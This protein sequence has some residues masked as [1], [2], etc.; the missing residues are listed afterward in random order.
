MTTT[1]CIISFGS[2]A[3]AIKKDGTFSTTSLNA[4]GNLDDLQDNTTVIK[5]FATYEPNFW[6]LD[7]SYKFVP[8]TNIHAGYISAAMSG[9]DTNF[10]AAP[11]IEFLFS[12][13]HSTTELKLKF[14]DSGD[15]ADSITINFFNGGSTLSSATYTPTSEEYTLSLTVTNFNK[16]ELYFNSTNKAYRYARLSNIE[17]DELTVFSGSSIK[18]AELVEQISP[19]SIELPINTI[20]FT[21]FSDT[22]DF[23][24]ANPSGMYASLQNKEAIEIRE[25]VNNSIVYIGTFYLD[26]WESK[27]INEAEFSAYD[28]IAILETF[29]FLGGYY[30][31]PVINSEDLIDEIF[32]A[33]GIDYE[34]DPT[35]S[36]IVVKGVIQYLTNCREALQQT[37][38]YLG[39]YATCAR[40]GIIRILPLPEVPGATGN[41]YELT[42]ANK[43]ISSPLTLRP[44]VTGVEIKQ[45]TYVAHDTGNL[46]YSGTL[47]VGSHF[48]SLTN[49][50]EKNIPSG[51]SQS[52]TA[53]FTITTN[54]KYYIVVNVTVAGT[55]IITEVSKNTH[56]D[57]IVGEYNPSLPAGATQNILSIDDA[58]LM[59]S[60]TGGTISTA[61]VAERVYDYY[62]RR[63]LQKTKL[64]ASLMKVGNSVLVEVQGGGQM[65][66]IVERMETNLSGGFV[67]NVEIVGDIV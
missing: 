33:A 66:G 58:T 19:I 46:L 27:S 61:Q 8:V 41:D 13:L 28:A 7:G 26:K 43:G 9:A 12:E 17:F 20:D 59:I 5:P 64:F 62:Q 56:S 50:S 25:L 51:I 4:I 35:L 52:G 15:W 49:S 55:V 31:S 32:T 21:L 29:T 57:T 42:S 36:G 67:S 53:T 30:G 39:A 48:I 38:F 1:S 37:L 44:F 47:G 14:S 10:S 54:R 34:L 65:S 2:N 18:S 6:L 22:G 40:S 60:A 45:T 11:K 16:I 3:I 24:V 23:N 63:F